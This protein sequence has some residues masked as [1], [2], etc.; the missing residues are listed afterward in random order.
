[1]NK[2]KALGQNFLVNTESI[3]SFLDFCNLKS[4]DKVL[5]IGLGE[6]ALTI[7]ISIKI[8]KIVCVEI[9][10]TL[11]DKSV[12]W[13]LENLQV[14]YENFLDC[15]LAEII[16]KNKIN[17]IVAAIPYSITSPIIHK[18]IKE[19]CLPLVDVNLIAQKEFTEKLV[20]DDKKRSY[21]TSL[22]NR[23]ASIKN[24]EKI[25]KESFNPIPKVDSKFFSFSFFDYP[26]EEKEVIKW[27]KFL[28]FV[29]ASPRKKINKRFKTEILESLDID[30]DKR[31]ENLD[32]P[33]LDKLYNTTREV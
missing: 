33:E 26:K 20:G 30:K 27:S 4:A 8:D 19:G 28:H 3:E 11:V 29:F 16:K 6:G 31:P 23:W 18:I 32:L 13:Q 17:K 2:T 22:V 7:P 9:D 1:M 15:N 21:F 25:E 10:K 14:I 12:Q 5:E 24:G